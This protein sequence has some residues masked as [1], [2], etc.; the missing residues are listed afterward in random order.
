MESNV[1]EASPH[2]KLDWGSSRARGPPFNCALC[3]AE[4][5]DSIGGILSHDSIWIFGNVICHNIARGCVIVGQF[6][7]VISRQQEMIGQVLNTQASI[8]AMEFD[9]PVVVNVGTRCLSQGE[10]LIIVQ[11]L[12]LEDMLVEIHFQDGGLVSPVYDAG[13]PHGGAQKEAGSIERILAAIAP[14]I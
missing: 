3:A 12:G 6:P 10:D 5:N 14:Q 1:S 7:L 4:G 9:P 11:K 13:M 2:E 8:Q